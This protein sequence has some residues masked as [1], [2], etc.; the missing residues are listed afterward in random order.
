MSNSTLK[1]RR[2]WTIRTLFAV[3]AALAIL[4]YSERPAPGAGTPTIREAFLPQFGHGRNLDIASTFTSTI[5]LLNLSTTTSQV[6]ILSLD[7]NGSSIPLLR[8]PFNGEARPSL[9]VPIPGSG[10]IVIQSANMNPDQIDVGSV[11][12]FSFN[13][14]VVSQTE[15]SIFTGDRLDARAQVP[16][17]PLTQGGSFLVGEQGQTGVAVVNPFINDLPAEVL[18]AS[19]DP[20]G[21]VVDTASLDLMPGQQISRFL[22]QLMD[23]QGAASAEFRSNVPIAILPL[24]QDGLV[25]TTQD[26]FPERNLNSFPGNS[27]N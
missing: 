1:Q 24:Q 15:F 19:V 13:D 2:N 21:N 12:I 10:T 26:L 9:S 27:G 11:S 4:S 14:S 3:L 8:D 18:L 22:D 7:P 25:L 16:S 6:S 17:R 23:T 20:A 5:S